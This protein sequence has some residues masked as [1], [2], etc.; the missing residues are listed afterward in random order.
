MRQTLIIRILL[1]VAALT[2]TNGW[3]QPRFVSFGIP[4]RDG[5]TLAADLFSIDTSIA[6]PLIVIQTPY[7]KFFLRYTLGAPEA[8]GTVLLFDSVHY[9]YLTVDWRGFYASSSA[10]S[11]G[12][13]RGLDGYDIIEW[14]AEQRWCNGRVGTWGVSAL[15]L[16]QFETMKH[17]PPHHVCAMPM[18]KDYKTKY[19]DFFPG[20]G[21]RVSF[22]YLILCGLSASMPNRFFLSASYSL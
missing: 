14:A 6:R 20:G 11:P 18:M 21:Y 2:A 5:K 16:I 15:G 8:T 19:T 9:N 3:A 13:D 10:G 1:L 22:L 4:V 17:R 12:Y 7:N